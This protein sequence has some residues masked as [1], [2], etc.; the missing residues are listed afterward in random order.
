MDSMG[1]KERVH[2][3]GRASDEDRGRI[4]E[5]ERGDAFDQNTLCACVKLSNKGRFKG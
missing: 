5:E 2:R 1:L 4:G 3:V